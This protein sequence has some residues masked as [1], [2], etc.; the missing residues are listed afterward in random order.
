MKFVGPINSAR[1][2][3]ASLKCALYTKEKSTIA[4]KKKKK[5]EEENANVQN[6]NPHLTILCACVVD[7]L[8][9][10]VFAF[11]LVS[12]MILFMDQSSDEKHMTLF[13]WYYFAI[14]IFYYRVY[15]NKF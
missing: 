9:A 13:P 6:V 8:R 15:N 7:F 2:P 12:P 5:K 3:L 1:D 14:K 10:F 4:T 11:Y